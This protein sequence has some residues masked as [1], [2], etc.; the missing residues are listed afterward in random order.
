MLYTKKGDK[1]TTVL[2]GCNQSISKSSAV[3]EALGALD[4][5]NSYLGICTASLQNTALKKP[6][7]L[8]NKRKVNIKKIVQ[9]VQKVLFLVQAEIAGAKKKISKTKVSKIEQIVDS[10]E[11]EMPQIKTFTIAGGT[12]ISAHFDVAR[13]ISRRAE[14]RVVEVHEEGLQTVGKNT[15]AYMNRLSSLLFALAR[16]IN[17]TDEVL[18]VSPKYK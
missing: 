17:Y 12:E 3:T 5:T 10:L 13:T 6:F 15:L 18:E 11:K 4:E 14:R 8:I 9:N 7:I 16:Y 1:G 2:F